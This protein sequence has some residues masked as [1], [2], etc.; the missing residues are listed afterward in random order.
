MSVKSMS[1]K[2]LEEQRARIDSE[3]RERAEQARQEA[4][5]VAEGRRDHFL[6]ILTRDMV[7]LLIPEHRRGSCDDQSLE[8]SYIYNGSVRCDR[9]YAL[10]VLKTQWMDHSVTPKLV[11]E[12]NGL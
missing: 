5:K 3:L 4:I 7:N 8:N 12:P 1:T 2:E 6:S 11:F 10:E 9:C